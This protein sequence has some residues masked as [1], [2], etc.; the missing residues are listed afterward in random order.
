MSSIDGPGAPPP[1]PPPPG[2]Q[3][4]SS[5]PIQGPARN[6]GMAIASLVCGIASFPVLGF[7]FLG[8]IPAVLAIIFSFVSKSQIAQSG[9]TQTG[10]G[11]AT[12]GLVLGIICIV[13]SIFVVVAI[14]SS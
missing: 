1:P 12:A 2:G 7:C 13:L 5:G 8:F 10:G 4:Q 9:G 6:N 11:M 14:A 3:W